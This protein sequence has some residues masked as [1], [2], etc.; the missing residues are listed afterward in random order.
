MLY[1]Q[2][3]NFIVNLGLQSTYCWPSGERQAQFLW[4]ACQHRA[5]QPADDQLQRDLPAQ[6][7]H[8]KWW[9]WREV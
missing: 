3:N 4:L 8:E 2:F 5:L 1:N 6:G 7:G 9:C